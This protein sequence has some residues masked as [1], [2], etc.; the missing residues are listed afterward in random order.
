MQIRQD[1]KRVV[2]K[3]RPAPPLIDWRLLMQDTINYGVD[4]SYT[5]AVLEDGMVRPVLEEIPV[6]ETEIVLDTSWSVDDELLKFP[7]CRSILP[8]S[9]MK[10]GCFITVFTADSTIRTERTSKRW[11]SGAAAVL[12]TSMPLRK[13]SPQ[14]RQRI[15]FTDTDR[16][17]ENPQLSGWYTVTGRSIL[18][19][20]KVIYIQ[21]RNSYDDVLKH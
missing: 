4:W 18:L 9:K 10:A 20:R 1:M 16:R 21:A 7:E 12:L 3:P 8:F 15:I 6:P 2:E 14:S 11:T 13:H 5:N 19:E 17:C